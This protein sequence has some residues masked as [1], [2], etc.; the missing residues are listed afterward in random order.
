M[1]SANEE[2]LSLIVVAIF[3]I[4]AIS[5]HQIL[6]KFSTENPILILRTFEPFLFLLSLSFKFSFLFHESFVKKIVELDL[7]LAKR[8]FEFLLS[9]SG[10]GE[11]LDE[12]QMLKMSLSSKTKPFVRLWFR[13]QGL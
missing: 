2:I 6:K 5:L 12:N 11:I 7:N 9:T 4:F 3:S 1:L 8:K 13:E 10:Q